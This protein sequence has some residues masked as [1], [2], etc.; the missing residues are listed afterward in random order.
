MPPPNAISPQPPLAGK[1]TEVKVIPSV[2]LKAAE[3]ESAVP[4]TR[5]GLDVTFH[6]C[7]LGN[8]LE[9]QVTPFGEVIMS[10]VDGTM[11]M[12]NA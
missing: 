9:V 10:V 2:D 8:A 11:N 12:S 3:L 4:T 6:V 5:L 1:V 7:E